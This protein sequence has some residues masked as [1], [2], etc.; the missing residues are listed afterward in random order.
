MMYAGRIV[1][2][3]PT[4]S[5]EDSGDPF[6]DQFVHRRAEGPIRITVD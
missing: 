5:I 6:V 4:G 1:W 2:Q 3:G